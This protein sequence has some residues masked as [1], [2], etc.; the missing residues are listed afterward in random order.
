MFLSC[1]FILSGWLF[2]GLINLI[3]HHLKH[4]VSFFSIL[5]KPF[6]GLLNSRGKGI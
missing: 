4:S 5:I 6:F 1:L 2:V 3:W